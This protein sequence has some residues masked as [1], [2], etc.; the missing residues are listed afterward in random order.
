MLKINLE[1][2]R[3]FNGILYYLPH[4]HHNNL[5]DDLFNGGEVLYVSY[6]P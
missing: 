2:W 6:F 1:F 5:P 3:R 4:S